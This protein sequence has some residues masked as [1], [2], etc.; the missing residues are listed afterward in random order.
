MSKSKKSE[1]DKRDM[2]SVGIDSGEETST[3]TIWAN[4]K[5]L[6]TFTFPMKDEG[7]ATLKEK[8]PLDTRV[9]FESSGTAYPFFRQ[10]RELG[11]TDIT[12]A[13]P[14]ELT[15][16]VKSKKK[17]DKVDS[18][19][20]AKLHSVGMI[21]EAHLLDREAQIFRDLLVQR[22]R[23]G[24]E[25]SKLK[26][27][28]TG[29]LKREGLYQGL[30]ASSDTFSVVRRKAMRAIAFGDE[31]D[32]VLST[33]L[34]RLEFA[35]EKAEP[36][37]EKIRARAKES[38]Q[39]KRLM[40]IPGVNFYLASLVDSYIGEVSRFPDADHLASFFG[41]VPAERNSSSIRRVGKMTKDGP[42]NSRMALSIMVDTVAMQDKQIRDYYAKEKAR[43]GSG[44][45]AH[46]LTMRKLVR[47][48][49]TM[50][51]RKENWRWERKALTERKLEKIENE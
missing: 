43:T 25:F 32:L 6:E 27:S 10:L 20:L 28:I 16:I 14:K 29:Y 46:V 1:H 21:P 8:V 3:A 50:L 18:I 24:A 13:H 41:I 40:S 22:V 23:L 51:T 42:S 48:I 2:P 7:Y 38:E 34:D 35:E 4:E 26:N 17:N 19:K 33:M 5:E 12:V 9:V 15:W 49:Y 37:E 47:M 36:F 39:V 11:Y 45:L 44:K 30:P 31:R